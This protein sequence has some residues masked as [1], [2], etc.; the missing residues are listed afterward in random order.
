MG[1]WEEPLQEIWQPFIAD[2]VK[3]FVS[4]A[5]LSSTSTFSSTQI[6]KAQLLIDSAMTF[7]MDTSRIRNS[8][9]NLASTS[10]FTANTTQTFAS[11][12]NLPAVSTLNADSIVVNLT[13]VSMNAQ[14]TFVGTGT[15]VQNANLNVTSTAQSTFTPTVRVPLQFQAQCTFSSSPVK[16]ELGTVDFAAISSITIQPNHIERVTFTPAAL[17]TLNAAGGSIQQST[18]QMQGFAAT[19]FLGELYK[20]DPERILTILSEIRSLQITEETRLFDLDIESRINIIAQETR[21][22]QILSETRNLVVQHNLLVDVAGTPRDRR[23][24]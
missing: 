9:V 8:Q 16:G 17:T 1:T 18:L 10:T 5:N 7:V 15:R 3:A 14:S 23:E 12:A 19:L 11:T 21:S 6:V 22:K 4:T 13:T 20:I 24:G 2:G